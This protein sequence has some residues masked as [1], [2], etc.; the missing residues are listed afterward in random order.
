MNQLPPL[1]A[2]ILWLQQ[3]D[4][5]ID[6]VSHL[7]L[8]RRCLVLQLDIKP[9]RL[10]LRVMTHWSTWIPRSNQ[11]R[12]VCA[13]KLLWYSVEKSAEL[14]YKVGS[15]L[16]KTMKTTALWSQA[17]P[18]KNSS[19]KA[20]HYTRGFPPAACQIWMKRFGRYSLQQTSYV[21]NHARR[22]GPSLSQ[23]IGPN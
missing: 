20:D 16:L 22:P 10:D 6:H 23:T 3:F 8:L 19:W 7:L 9:K 15:L 2:K 21:S 1:A 11:G 17:S 18:S 13:V 4:S 12:E 14:N 5:K